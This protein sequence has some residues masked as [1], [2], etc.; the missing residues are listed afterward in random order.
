[1]GFALWVLL[2][3]TTS[4]TRRGEHKV[5]REIVDRCQSSR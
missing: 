2:D 4:Q 5:T 3:V 1:M